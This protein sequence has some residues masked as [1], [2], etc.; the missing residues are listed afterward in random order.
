MSK[1]TWVNI[2]GIWK[3]CKAVWLNVGGTWKKATNKINVN[4]IW[5]DC[6][7]YVVEA[8]TNVSFGSSTAQSSIQTISLKDLVEI[9]S[10]TVDNG[11][12]TYTVNGEN[13]TINVNNGS[14]YSHYSPYMYSRNAGAIKS[15]ST[16]S[17]PDSI[18]FSSG[19]YSGTLYKSG[20]S[21]VSSGIYTPA[22]SKFVTGQSSSNYNSGGYSGTLSQYVAS[23][24]YTQ[25]DSKQVKFVRA[26]P[27]SETYYYNQDGYSGIL[28]RVDQDS[29]YAIYIGTVTRPSVDTRVY[30]YQGTVTRPAVDTREYSQTYSGYVYMG[31]YYSTYSYQVNI[32]YTKKA[33]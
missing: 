13:V 6:I 24:S 26:A 1:A 9:K 5:K 31:G 30:A 20:S 21:T 16:D 27:S 22:D 29:I 11:T 17:F 14:A 7:M 2:N 19:G 23:G 8:T 28:P 4:G 10:V 25:A 12:V 18:P 15:S 33:N 3:Q 32:I